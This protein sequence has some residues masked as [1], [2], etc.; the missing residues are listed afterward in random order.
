MHKT[1]NTLQ[2]Y[3]AT[4]VEQALKASDDKYDKL[5]RELSS[6]V[7]E[8]IKQAVS[9]A[10]HYDNRIET[11]YNDLKSN[12]KLLRAI[13]KLHMST[14]LLTHQVKKEIV[15]VFYKHNINENDLAILDEAHNVVNAI[16]SINLLQHSKEHDELNMRKKLAQT[17]K[18][19]QAE[20]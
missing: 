15:E 17:I 16:S 4:Y 3:I 2:N 1:N 13:T 18:R 8:I 9:E 12:K 10:K 14:F 20:N 6:K 5:Y 19:P 11:V 7:E